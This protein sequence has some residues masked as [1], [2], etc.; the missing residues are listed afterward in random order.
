MVCSA[1]NEEGPASS[2]FLAYLMSSARH[3]LPL[4][5][6]FS[7]RPPVC[8]HSR[9]DEAMGCDHRVCEFKFHSVSA[10]G[11]SGF[12]DGEGIAIWHGRVGTE[13]VGMRRLTAVPEAERLALYAVEVALAGIDAGG[14]W[15]PQTCCLAVFPRRSANRSSARCRESIFVVAI[16]SASATKESCTY[17][18]RRR[19]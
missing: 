9:S 12:P 6:I 5:L 13:R 18:S 1:Q 17:G 14:P 2:R 3:C 15:I 10:L 4:G 7:A 8:G 11:A 16:F 19:A